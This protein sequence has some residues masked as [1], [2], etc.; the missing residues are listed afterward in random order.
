MYVLGGVRHDFYARNPAENDF[1][2]VPVL[3]DTLA[4]VLRFDGQ[5]W[6]REHDLP[7]GV[8]HVEA[9][10]LTIP[11]RN[12]TTASALIVGGQVTSP[13]EVNRLSNAIVLFAPFLDSRAIDLEGT[14]TS[15]VVG[16]LPVRVKG[17]IAWVHD[18]ELFFLGGQESSG[19]LSP[20]GAF[21]KVTWRSRLNTSKM[22]P[23]Y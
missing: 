4:T 23:T 9:S 12:A 1:S 11:L 7:F 8:S 5:V 10:T 13:D 19:P 15:R 18:S 14:R 3:E 16:M 21:G 2:C 22:G 20:M 17:M 6:T